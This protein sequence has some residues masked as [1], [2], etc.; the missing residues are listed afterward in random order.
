M[1]GGFPGDRFLHDLA[2]QLAHDF[3]IGHPTFQVETLAE[4]GCALESETVV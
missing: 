2:H 1:P 3:G 4:T